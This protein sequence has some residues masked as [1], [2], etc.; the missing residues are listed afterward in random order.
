MMK[1]HIF[2]DS[3]A[4]FCFSGMPNASNHAINSITMHRVGRDGLKIVN[5]KASGARDGDIAFFIFGEVDCRCH[6]ERQVAMGRVYENVLSE[7]IDS[8]FHTL[9]LNSS[10]FRNLHIVIVSIVPPVRHSDYHGAN[11]PL[12]SDHPFPFVGSDERRVQITRDVNS[13]LAERAKAVG[14]QFLNIYDFYS[15]P[16]DGT[17]KFELSDRVCHIKDNTYILEQ[18]LKMISTLN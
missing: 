15:R 11:P 4:R 6:I 16:E 13:A 2:G 10:Q 9:A 8:Y 14:Y 18:A 1:V 12:Q 3:H 7:L 5:C 17:L